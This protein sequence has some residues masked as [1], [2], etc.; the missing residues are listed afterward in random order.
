[1]CASAK[2]TS[3]SSMPLKQTAEFMAALAKTGLTVEDGQKIINSSGNALAEKMV[4]T[5]SEDLYWNDYFKQVG[6]IEIDVPHV[7]IPSMAGYQ[8]NLKSIKEEGHGVPFPYNTNLLEKVDDFNEPTL[9]KL[10]HRKYFI[11]TFKIKENIGSKELKG[12]FKKQGAI[13]MGSYGFHLAI[14]Y[15]QVPFDQIIHFYNGPDG[16]FKK[17]GKPH[18]FTVTKSMTDTNINLTAS[19]LEMRFQNERLV[20][21]CP[22]D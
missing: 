11:K 17:D 6:V 15:A 14:H 3:I 19:E 9:N 2:R 20:L 22:A 13:N 4:M 5:I 8:S 10:Q 16:C 1:M 7:N 18:M 12:F 21:F